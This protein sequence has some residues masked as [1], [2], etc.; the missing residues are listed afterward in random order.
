[1]ISSGNRFRCYPTEEQKLVFSQWMGCQRLIYNATVAEDAYFCTFS[2][3]SLSLIGLK[4]PVD[5]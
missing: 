3:K 5:K 1:M 2:K 4:F